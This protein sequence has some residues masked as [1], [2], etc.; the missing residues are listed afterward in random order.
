MSAE[1]YLDPSTTSLNRTRMLVKIISFVVLISALAVLA[2]QL[3]SPDY[4]VIEDNLIFQRIDG[5]RQSFK[6]LKGKPLIVTFWSPTCT[7]CM[8][9]V[10]G[11]NALYQKNQADHP[12]ELLAL[13]MYYDRP[14]LIVQASQ[15]KGMSYPVYL[16]LQNQIA[17]AFGNIVATPTTFILDTSG[18]IIYRHAGK[19][20]FELIAQKLSQLSG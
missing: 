5:T 12:F 4:P 10:G 8:H 13:S 14:D 7:I 20:D 18:D 1:L 2:F 15:Q 19:L 6:D 17:Q 11:W 9:E 3:H 16:D